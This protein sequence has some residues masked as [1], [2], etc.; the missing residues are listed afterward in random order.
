MNRGNEPTTRKCGYCSGTGYALTGK[1]EFSKQKLLLVEGRDDERFFFALL[2]N[3]N[4]NDIHIEIYEGKKNLPATLKS[5]HVR[6][7]FN[8]L[9]SIAIIRDADDKIGQ[10]VF[11]EIVNVLKKTSLSIPMSFA[12][13]SH[14]TPKVGIFVIP[15]KDKNGE[16]EDFLLESITTNS[17]MR[18]VDSFI[19]CIRNMKAIKKSAKFRLYAWISSQE[20]PGLK[21]GQAADIG[22]FDFSHTSFSELTNFINKLHTGK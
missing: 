9:T 14:G 21:L 7:G 3:K 11:E 6:P 8:N 18:C 4:I 1:H 2:K 5:L 22:L 15:G 13:F 20:P 17:E 12:E 10:I 19:N 16:L